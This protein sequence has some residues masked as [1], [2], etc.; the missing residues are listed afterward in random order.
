MSRENKL[1]AISIGIKK[2]QINISGHHS[3]TGGKVASKTHKG[4]VDKDVEKGELSSFCC[5]P[6][7]LYHRAMTI[8]YN[9]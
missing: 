5:S 8:T 3:I 7:S 2:T 9:I 6:L 4:S 1:P